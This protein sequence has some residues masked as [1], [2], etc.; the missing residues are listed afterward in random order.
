MTPTDPVTG[1]WVRA[2]NG[3]VNAVPRAEVIEAV[4]LLMSDERLLKLIRQVT[5]KGR[6]KR[7]AQ[8]DMFLKLVKALVN[9]PRTAARP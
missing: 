1:A 4:R 5:L 3:D 8:D 9:D 7:Y 2:M 6:A